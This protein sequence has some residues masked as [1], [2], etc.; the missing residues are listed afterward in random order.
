MARGLIVLPK[1]RGSLNRRAKR[2]SKKRTP[3][4][5][6][7]ATTSKLFRIVLTNQRARHNG[8]KAATPLAGV[9]LT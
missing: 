4:G 7:A 9:P 6:F 1:M 3:N 8:P 2:T 5:L